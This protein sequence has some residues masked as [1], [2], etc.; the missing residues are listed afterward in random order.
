M[1]SAAVTIALLVSLQWAPLVESLFP[2]EEVDRAL[3]VIRYESGGQPDKVNTAD[4]EGR[5]GSVGLFQIA[6]DNWGGA[7]RVAGLERWPEVSIVQARRLLKV[8]T[9]NVMAAA[10]MWRAEGWLPAWAAQRHR[11]GLTE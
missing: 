1:I 10:A 6:A 3:C 8:P 11:C 9:I 5:G 2:P 4:S 7:H